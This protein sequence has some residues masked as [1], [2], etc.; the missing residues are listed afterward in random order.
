MGNYILK[1]VPLIAH[2]ILCVLSEMW[3]FRSLYHHHHPQSFH[4]RD[5]FFTVEITLDLQLIVN[6]S[7]SHTPTLSSIPLSYINYF[8][9]IRSSVPR[10]TLTFIKRQRCRLSHLLP[11]LLP[12]SLFSDLLI[13]VLHSSSTKRQILTF[14]FI[15]TEIILSVSKKSTSF[16]LRPSINDHN[17]PTES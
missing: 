8:P 13:P 6:R 7:S 4:C 17:Q 3:V 11:I 10:T 12:Y 15:V 2:E 9:D 5:S 16:I 1:R 14:R